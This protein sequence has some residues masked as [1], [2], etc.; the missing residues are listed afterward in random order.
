MVSRVVAALAYTSL[1]LL[2][3]QQVQQ[4]QNTKRESQSASLTSRRALADSVPTRAVFSYNPDFWQSR[5]GLAD[6]RAMFREEGGAS[7]GEQAIK[8]AKA[9]KDAKLKAAAEN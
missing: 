6:P 9:I 5:A 2:D 7:S 3:G 1:T 8:R 4:G